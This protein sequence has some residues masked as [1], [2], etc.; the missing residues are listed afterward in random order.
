MTDQS[1]NDELKPPALTRTGASAKTWIAAA[2]VTLLV[3]GIAIAILGRSNNQS[4]STATASSAASTGQGAG[5]FPGGGRGGT[6]G[7]ISS[8]AGTNL[9]ITG[10]DGTTTNVVTDS[11]TSVT[12]SVT[13]SISDI[14]VG[15][16]ITAMGTTT[17]TSVAADR[18]VDNATGADPTGPGGNFPG[19]PGASP[20]GNSPGGPGASPSGQTPPTD[21]SGNPVGP[22]PGGGQGRGPGGGV[23]GKVTAVQGSTITIVD[24]NGT[25]YAVTASSTTVVTRTT[26]ATFADLAIGQQV[27]VN[28]TPAS[29]G[30]VTARRISEGASAFGSLAG[31]SGRPNGQGNSTTSIAAP[32]STT[33]HG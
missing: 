24:Q 20:G 33:T 18:I 4:T 9:T 14:A 6:A 26:A 1:P 5:G 31:P 28:G 12:H 30:T 7:T 19:G 21:Q 13:A 3:V 10:S 8:I 29:D 15:D 27:M 17:G 11:S 22:P 23:R 32:T 16:Q 2:V 25:T